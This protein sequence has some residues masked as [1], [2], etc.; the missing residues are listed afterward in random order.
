[1]GEWEASLHPSPNVG[2]WCW[3]ITPNCSDQTGIVLG[4]LQ[5]SVCVREERK[6]SLDETEIL[7]YFMWFCLCIGYNGNYDGFN[8]PV[9]LKQGYVRV[10]KVIFCQ[11]LGYLIRKKCVQYPI[12]LI[13][14][15]YLNLYHVRLHDVDLLCFPGNRGSDRSSSSLVLYSK[16][17]RFVVL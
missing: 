12:V 13:L 15:S 6:L 2:C 1:M 7:F 11:V 10:T 5:V 3:C 16:N 8:A 14:L 17:Q 4:S 9:T